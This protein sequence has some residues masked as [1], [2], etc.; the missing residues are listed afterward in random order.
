M[1]LTGNTGE[2]LSENNIIAMSGGGLDVRLRRQVPVSSRP[3]RL[4][5]GTRALST[6]QHAKSQSNAK[7]LKEN[8]PADISQ[9]S[10]F[11]VVGS[12]PVEKSA[13]N[14]NDMGSSVYNQFSARRAVDSGNNNRPLIH[15]QRHNLKNRF[16]LLRTLGEG[17]YGKVKLASDKTT[18]EQVAIKYIKKTKIQDEND[19]VRIRREIQILSSLRHKHIVNIREVFEKKDKIVL[20]MDY[21]QGGE[22]YDYLNR[23][24]KL[25]EWDARRIFRQI[26][27][28]IHYC[29]QNGIVHRD[30]KLENIIL[31]DQGNVKI[32]DFGLSNYY[33]HNSTLKTFCG[34]PLYASPEIV[35]GKPYHGPEVDVWSLGVILYTLV[36]GS[37]PFESNSLVSLKQQISEGDYSQ[38]SRPSDAA[39]LIR[40][41]LTVTP[42][43]RATMEDALRHWWVNLGHSLMPN[44]A[45]YSPDDEPPVMAY[46]L[47]VDESAQNG[48]FPPAV[49][50]QRNQSSISSDSDVELDFR[51]SRWTTKRKLALD[52]TGSSLSSSVAGSPAPTPDSGCGVGGLDDDEVEDDAASIASGLLKLPPDVLEILKG[53]SSKSL[54][55]LLNLDKIST[56]FDPDPPARESRSNSDGA[57]C[58]GSGSS[59]S[60]VSGSGGVDGAEN[61]VT[62][63]S[64]P[65]DVDRR[66]L[67]GDVGEKL[68]PSSSVFDSER[69]PKRGILKRKGKFSGGDSGCVVHEDMSGAGRAEETPMPKSGHLPRRLPSFRDEA[70]GIFSSKHRATQLLEASSARHHHHEGCSSAVSHPSWCHSASCS[71]PLSEDVVRLASPEQ[72]SGAHDLQDIHHDHHHHH[73]EQQQQQHHHHYE[74][75]QQQQHH[76]HHHQQ[77]QQQQQFHQPARLPSSRELEYLARTLSQL[78]RDNL[79]PQQQQQQQKQQ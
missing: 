58:G 41:M 17:T 20:V 9:G 74:Q 57:V 40:H 64:Y 22:L 36:Y 19:L 14:D 12:G 2:Q 7:F 60:G 25:G 24:G 26:V 77:Q 45:P 1:H 48:G 72:D 73:Y 5:L 50:H 10:A 65:L 52:S 51:P 13:V 32:A 66:R 28:A 33:S 79:T 55:A 27:S 62:S 49:I 29:H 78:H 37:M 59:S 68:S 18:G 44:D 76:H 30:L 38:P 42:S 67:S 56:G 31:D 3:P 61:N 21:A 47:C 54:A 35:N 39:G 63:S 46:T 16:Q 8:G 6:Q 75:Q 43:R 53:C 69:K 34:S 11:S 71:A 15:H 70:H 23:M 4:R